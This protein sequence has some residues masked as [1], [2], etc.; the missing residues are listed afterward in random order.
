MD[1][2][3]EFKAA[4]PDADTGELEEQIDWLVYELYGL[5]NSEVAA[6]EGKEGK[7]HATV[8]EEDTALLEAMLEDD[9]ND[10]SDIRG[11]E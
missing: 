10:R 4:D 3:I 1:E 5:T 8:E 6:I 2:I 11:M 9:I 7:V